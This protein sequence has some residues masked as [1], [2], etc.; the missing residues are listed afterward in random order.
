MV[1]H[2]TKK[3]I[4][5][6]T[7]GESICFSPVS[8]VGNLLFV[9]KLNQTKL[10]CSSHY[11]VPFEYLEYSVINLI[12]H[13]VIL[14]FNLTNYCKN[15]RHQQVRGWESYMPSAVT[16][17]SS[18]NFWHHISLIILVFSLLEPSWPQRLSISCAQ[19]H[20]WTLCH[21][22][23]SHPCS[24][25]SRPPSLSLHCQYFHFCH[26]CK[27]VAHQCTFHFIVFPGTCL[28]YIVK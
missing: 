10:Y 14:N 18:P 20:T 28:P 11:W 25:L 3:Q 17:A 5:N 15:R 4:T 7:E 13:S 1:D 22:D 2:L 26:H 19:T 23:C 16:I 6:A 24:P 27:V 9:P 8:G 12:V 21:Q